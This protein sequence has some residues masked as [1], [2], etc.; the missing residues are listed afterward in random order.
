[1]K[2]QLP[3]QLHSR[4]S[5]II[6]RHHAQLL[7]HS[8]ASTAVCSR[9]SECITELL[10]S[11][12]DPAFSWN[13]KIAFIIPREPN[14]ETTGDASHRGGG[15]H[16]VVF[17]FWF[18]LIWSDEVVY[19]T[20][21]LPPSDPRYIHINCL[22]FVVVIIQLIATIVLFRD[23]TPGELAKQFPNGVPKFPILKSWTDNTPSKG[24]ANKVTAKSRRGQY[25]LGL[26]A[27]LLRLYDVGVN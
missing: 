23:S 19:R 15:G 21:K 26:Y 10:S 13:A 8:S 3:N 18:D 2:K 27:E 14:I 20:K 12:T 4:I 9:V 25:L 11:F 24:W 7:W 5:S 16:S 6:S 1:M 22:E 17:E